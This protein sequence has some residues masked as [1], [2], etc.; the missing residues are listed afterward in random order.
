[1]PALERLVLTSEFLDSLRALS[2]ANQGRI[3]RA[4]VLLNDNDRH[5]SLNAHPL[6]GTESGIWAVYASRS[7]R[8]TFRRLEAVWSCSRQPNTTA[9]ERG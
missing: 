2:S 1:M 8:I 3:F 4:L 7:L 6:R 9:T 5:P